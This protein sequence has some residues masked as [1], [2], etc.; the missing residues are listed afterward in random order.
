M[1]KR[2]RRSKQT[3]TLAE[4]LTQEATRMRDRATS[5]SPGPEQAE[6]WRKVYQAEAALR[7]EAWLA[8]DGAHPP[9]KVMLLVGRSK[10]NVR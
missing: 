1:V 10:R 9:D 5:L 2:R 7:I 6:L 8:S 4:R 3:T